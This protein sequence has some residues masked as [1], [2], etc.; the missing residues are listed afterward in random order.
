MTRKDCNEECCLFRWNKCD[1]K[2]KDGTCD[3]P[4]RYDQGDEFYPSYIPEVT[5]AWHQKNR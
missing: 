1:T 2:N 3:K 5:K 4:D